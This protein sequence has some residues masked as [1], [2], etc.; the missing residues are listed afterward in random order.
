V[1]FIQKTIFNFSCGSGWTH[2]AFERNRG[3]NSRFYNFWMNRF[4][5]FAYQLFYFG[6]LGYALKGYC[7]LSQYPWQSDAQEQSDSSQVFLYRIRFFLFLKYNCRNG[8]ISQNSNH[9]FFLFRQSCIFLKEAI[10]SFSFSYHPFITAP[11]TT[12]R[13][14]DKLRDD[15]TCPIC[16]G[17]LSTP[18][19]GTCGHVV[20][21]EHTEYITPCCPVCR[22]SKAFEKPIKCQALC[23]LLLALDNNE[24][25]Q[26]EQRSSVKPTNSSALRRS[27]HAGGNQKA[28]KRRLAHTTSVRARTIADLVSSPYPSTSTTVIRLEEERPVTDELLFI[29]HTRGI[30]ATHHS[31]KLFIFP[32]LPAVS[33]SS[34]KIPP[35]TEIEAAS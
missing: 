27:M 33:S 7:G 32:S 4:F 35:I 22:H 20:C 12:R 29:L 13:C 9:N 24:D 14:M 2:D 1:L 28:A 19:L 34:I 21:L 11:M 6:I 17:R 8:L 10:A 16:M 23:T 15:L 5:V 26:Q 31:G 25:E 18:V 3:R 30:R